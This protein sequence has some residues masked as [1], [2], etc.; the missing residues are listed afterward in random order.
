[1]KEAFE[2]LGYTPPVALI[3]EMKGSDKA[4]TKRNCENFVKLMGDTRSLAHDL[5]WKYG[6]GSIQEH[7]FDKNPGA[8]AFQVFISAAKTERFLFR[9]TP[10]AGELPNVKARL[11]ITCREISDNLAIPTELDINTIV[12]KGGKT[13]VIDVT[14]TLREIVGK[15]AKTVRD[16]EQRLLEFHAPLL[17]A[18]QK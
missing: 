17:L 10:N 3:G 12:R 9:V 2:Y 8:N 18:L 13:K 4:E 15:K 6:A 11:E 1:M 16:I 5:G 14:T 7:Y